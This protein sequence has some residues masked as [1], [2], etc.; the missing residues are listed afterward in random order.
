MLY[1]FK[2]APSPLI[3][4]SYDLESPFS[5]PYNKG[6][7][8]TDGDF[9]YECEYPVQKGNFCSQGFFGIYSFSK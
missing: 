8:H 3:R 9:L 4:F 2:S 5:S 7:A 6:D 1:R